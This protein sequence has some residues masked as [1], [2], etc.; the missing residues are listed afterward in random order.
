MTRLRSLVL[1]SALLTPFVVHAQGTPAAKPAAKSGEP[2]KDPAGLKGIS[3]FW[4]AIKK[5]DNLYIAR[6]YDGAIAAYQEALRAE[7]KN[8]MGHYRIGEAYRAKGQL[9]EA[10]RAWIDA[11]RFVGRDH[12][13]RAKLIFVL[14][15]LRERK[16][17]L[18]KAKD[19]WAAYAQFAQQQANAKPPVPTYPNTPPERQKRVDAWKE[20][21]EKYKAVKTRIEAKRKESEEAARKDATKGAK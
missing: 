11:V 4:E 16:R 20:Q 10:E 15:D 19:Q 9:E 1:I 3:P 8:A 18:D 12:G 7:A 21:V 6:D 5:G 17:E 13:L 14:A 2:K